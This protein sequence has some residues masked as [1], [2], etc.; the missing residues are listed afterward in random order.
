MAPHRASVRWIIEPYSVHK[1]GF[2]NPPNHGQNL[3]WQRRV[4]LQADPHTGAIGKGGKPIEVVPFQRAAPE[5]R[6]YHSSSGNQRRQGPRSPGRQRGKLG[7]EGGRDHPCLRVQGHNK[8]PLISQ[9]SVAPK[10]GNHLSDK[11]F[12]FHGLN[13]V[14]GGVR[15]E[16]AGET[17]EDAVHGEGVLIFQQGEGFAVFPQKL[18][19]RAHR[20]FFDSGD[21]LAPEPEPQ[22]RK[23]H[24]QRPRRQKKNRQDPG[25]HTAL[26]G[27]NFLQ[28]HRLD[29]WRGRRCPPSPPRNCNKAPEWPREDLTAFF[30]GSH[31][32]EGG[33]WS[34]APALLWFAFPSAPPIDQRL[35]FT[36]Q[37]VI[38][39][40]HQ[41][42]IR[43]KRQHQGVPLP[44]E[45]L[46]QRREVRKTT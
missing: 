40:R 25:Q 41:S 23:G 44:G 37:K 9:R 35:A 17:V 27:D 24:H 22:K 7:R 45:K 10:P 12:H 32:Q 11:K 1:G 2:P 16:N 19:H 14:G 29:S 26:Q 33:S 42:P 4:D 5:E 13:V 30:T 34:L 46:F 20:F 39:R 21:D 43:R 28:R 15:D 8:D 38:H 36:A 31:D 6:E 18:R 3:L